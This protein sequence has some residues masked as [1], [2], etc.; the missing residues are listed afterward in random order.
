MPGT[1]TMNADGLDSVLV[2]LAALVILLVNP[3]FASDGG[4]TAMITAVADA[5]TRSHPKEG[6]GKHAVGRGHAKH[7]MR[8][9]VMT[10]GVG[11]FVQTLHHAPFPYYG[12]YEDTQVDFFDFIDPLSGHRFHTNRYGER[13][14]ER[15]HYSDA[16]VLFH[17]PSHFDPRK[18][19]AY[20]LYFHGLGTDVFSSDRDYEL[21]RQ[22]DSSGRNVILVVPQLAKNAADSSP[23]KFFRRNGFRAFMDEVGGVMTSRFGKE[24]KKKFS[25]APIILTAFSGG[26]KSVAY[27]LDRGGVNDRVEGVFLM[28]ALYDDVDKFQRWIGG[29]IRRSFLVS[30]YTHGK[31]SENMKDLLDRVPKRGIRVRMEWPQTLFRGSIHHVLCDTDH[32]RIPLA[33]PPQ[34]PLASLLKLVDIW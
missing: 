11:T 34:D 17:V 25:G 7:S 4:L 29:N 1:E 13:Y 18:R 12:K 24:F 5:P 27:I 28:D 20:V 14:S 8:I 9:L 16:R 26:Y 15:E 2:L 3:C 21:A 22:M 33:G 6:H 30:L 31:C 32:M 19:I 10:E 23:G